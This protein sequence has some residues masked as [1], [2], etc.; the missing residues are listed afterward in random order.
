MDRHF[1]LD[2]PENVNTYRIVGIVRDARFAGFNL[3]QPPRPMFYVPL[4]QAVAYENPL[5][6]RLEIASHA[7]RGILL[8]TDQPTATLEPLLMRTLAAADPNLTIT[9]VRTLQQQVDRAFDQQ[10]AV[11]SLAGLFG[12][13]ALILAAIGLYGVTAYA[14]AQR[15]REIGVR[16]ALGAGRRR[17]VTMVL[18]SAFQRVGVGLVLG[19]PLAVGAG[20]LLSAQ[21]YGVSFWDPM[22]LGAGVLALGASAFVAAILPARRAAS[23]SPIRALRTD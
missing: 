3:D 8:V 12:I 6:K 13:V 19:L 18:G 11:A 2:L 21:L 10:R 4:A 1:G 5:M 17:V 20:Y 23:I 16:M 9:N 22:A 7:V 14:V 15:T